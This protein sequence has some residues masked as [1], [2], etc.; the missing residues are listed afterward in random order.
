LFDFI[1]SDSFNAI[2]KTF[3]KKKQKLLNI[4]VL[5]TKSV[6]KRNRSTTTLRDRYFLTMKRKKEQKNAIEEK[7]EM[8]LHR[9]FRKRKHS[10]QEWLQLNSEKRRGKRRKKEPATNNL[11]DRLKEKEALINRFIE[12]GP[13]I[14]PLK[15]ELLHLP[16]LTLIK[17]ITHH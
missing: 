12:T 3:L 10:F 9:I 8:E 5:V 6:F 17:M 1:T 2:Q 7:L 15:T 16:I 4:T 13:K 14:A 11:I